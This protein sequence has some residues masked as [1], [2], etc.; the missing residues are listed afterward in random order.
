MV[1]LPTGRP[2]DTYK[3]LHTVHGWKD[4]FENLSGS[5]QG[6]FIK[7]D[8]SPVDDN[9]VSLRDCCL[10][11]VAVNTLSLILTIMAGLE[12]EIPDLA[13]RTKLTIHLVGA[14]DQELSR[15]HMFEELY[16]LLP[17]LQALVIGYVGPD[18]GPSVGE[19]LLIGCCPQCQEM[20]RGVQQAFLAN[21]LYH[22]FVKSELF[23][24]YPPDLIVALH[25]GHATVSSWQPTLPSILDLGI[26]AVFTTYNKQEALDEG[27]IFDEMG[28]HFSRRPAEN[29]WRG[30]LPLF[31]AFEGRYDV[32][33]C[34][35]YWY[36]VKGR[37]PGLTESEINGGI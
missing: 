5:S 16:H 27:Q 1:Q 17:N 35:Y 9:E 7:M 22:D 31:E 37:K 29:P 4:Y 6:R 14:D 10:L 8:F 25:T 3:P 33:Y 28:A 21:D 11:K 20:D 30:V 24:K 2:R 26:P 36:I 34:N 18:V 23:A 15:A 19:L 13:S 32:Y 12:S